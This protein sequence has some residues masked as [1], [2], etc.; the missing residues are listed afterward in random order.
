M[1]ENTYVKLENFTKAI[2]GDAIDE[3]RKIYE[4]IR[5]VSERALAAAEDEALGE[6][7]RFVKNEVAKIRTEAG[8]LVSRK[9]MENKRRLSLRRGEICAECVLRV[10]ERI[11][12]YVA[13]D[14]YAERLRE[15]AAKALQVF[16]CDAVFYLRKEDMRLADKILP[17]GCPHKAEFREGDFELGGL[18]AY[19]GD[20]AMQID[21]SFDTTLEELGEHFAELIG[22]EIAGAFASGVAAEGVS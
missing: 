18:R 3:S 6:S 21:E 4:E 17:P 13:T 12:A 1:P 8:R 11:A 16:S 14:E 5:L 19:C 10:R 2:T 20:K 7:F 9:L 15:L 22:L